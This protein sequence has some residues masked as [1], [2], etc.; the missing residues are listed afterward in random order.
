MMYIARSSAIASRN[1]GG[2]TIVMS[3]VDS[4]LFT[5]NPVAT[6][7]WESADGNTTLRAIVEQRVCRDFAVDADAAYQDASSFVQ[8]LAQH[9]IL[10]VS[11]DPIGESA[12]LPQQEPR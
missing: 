5:L 11:P 4:T 3:A 8:E 1:L 9:G 10:L 2:E 12:K 7:I 6:A